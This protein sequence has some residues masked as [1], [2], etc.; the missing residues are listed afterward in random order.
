MFYKI[1]NKLPFSLKLPLW[2]DSNCCH[3][4]PYYVFDEKTSKYDLKKYF[5]SGI[6]NADRY[7]SRSARPYEQIANT[8]ISYFS[9]KHSL[10]Y[11]LE[12]PHWLWPNE[13]PP[14]PPT[15]PPP[16]PQKKNVEKIW[17]TDA[18]INSSSEH[19][20]SNKYKRLGNLAL[21]SCPY[22]NNWHILVNSNNNNS[23]CL[24]SCTVDTD[25]CRPWSRANGRC[26]YLPL[27][28]T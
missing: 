26:L 8:C 10:G 25:Q 2:D 7:G 18:Y 17:K 21:I 20:Q 27:F 28:P 9:W 3:Y 14:Q 23:N 13:L 6:F 24:I 11:S 12:M 1:S 15:P 19:L 4:V 16:P 5:L 22:L